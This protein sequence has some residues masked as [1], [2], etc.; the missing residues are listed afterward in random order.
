VHEGVERTFDALGAVLIPGA[1]DRGLVSRI[2]AA[3]SGVFAKRDELQAAGQVPAQLPSEYERR[4]VALDKL[5]LGDALIASVLPTLVLDVAARYLA[6]RP[7]PAVQTYVRQILP[8]RTDTYLPF[9][10]D[11]SIVKRRLVNVWI[12]LTACGVDAPGLELVLRSAGTLLPLSP[13]DD[14]R[15][16]V[17]RARIAPETIAARFEPDAFW[18]PTFEPGDVLVFAGATAHRTFASPGMTRSRMSLEI[19]LT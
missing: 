11:E 13:P 14:A 12:P 9:H 18:R 17:E 5:G 7:E 15:F 1:V 10:Q 16:P 4:F 19:R 6:K 2:A 8:V 3:A